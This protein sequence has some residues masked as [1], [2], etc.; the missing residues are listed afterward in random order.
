ML[1]K[2]IHTYTKTHTISLFLSLSHTGETNQITICSVC[3]LALSR[4]LSRAR[5]RSFHVCL[6]LIHSL[7]HWRALSRLLSFAIHTHTL[8]HTHTHTPHTH[9]LSLSRT[10]KHMLSFANQILSTHAVERIENCFT[11]RV[12]V[13]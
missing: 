11:I 8:S 5:A 1:C 4:S 3:S 12:C 10:H 6:S 13:Q 2:L 9:T 7:N